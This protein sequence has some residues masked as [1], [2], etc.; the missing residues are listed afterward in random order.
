MMLEKNPRA[1][2]FE[3]QRLEMSRKRWES[4]LPIVGSLRCMNLD[5]L[6]KLALLSFLSEDES[7]AFVL[8]Q[9]H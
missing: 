3:S 5:S 1:M 6:M 8:L 2:R 7:G 4:Q 9:T